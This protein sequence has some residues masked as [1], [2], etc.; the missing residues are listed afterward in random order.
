M[1]HCRVIPFAEPAEKHLDK[2]APVVV[3][4]SIIQLGRDQNLLALRARV[5][6]SSGASVHSIAPEEAET[7]LA[8]TQ[9]PKIWIF[10][11]TL[12]FREFV[13]LATRVRRERPTDKLLRLNGLDEARS[14]KDLVDRWL[15]P[16][17]TV[18]DLLRMV[19]DLGCPPGP[20]L[21]R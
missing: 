5:I 7:E 9:M 1:A 3:R 18:E 17:S 8:N 21:T 11:H 16:V 2:T 13:S 4:R 15:E 14:S 19:A 10:C 12:E 20:S 6:E